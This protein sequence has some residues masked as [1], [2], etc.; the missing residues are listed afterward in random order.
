MKSLR[1][2]MA[3]SD[4]CCCHKVFRVG[5][6]LS[7]FLLFIC[8]LAGGG[9]AV[10][11]SKINRNESERK[12]ATNKKGTEKT[13]GCKKPFDMFER[14]TIYICPAPKIAGEPFKSCRQLQSAAHRPKPAVY[15]SK[16]V[17]VSALINYI[18]SHTQKG[19]QLCQTSLLCPALFMCCHRIKMILTQTLK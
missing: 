14:K 6:K 16:P 15:F 1:E 3:F 11:K 17:V 19:F 9:E 5:Q 18:T 10:C 8:R 12:I 2:T 7:F 4:I 13:N